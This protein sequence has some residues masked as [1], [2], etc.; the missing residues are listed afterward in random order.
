MHIPILPGQH[1]RVVALSYQCL[2]LI[3]SHCPQLIVTDM[4]L[5]QDLFDAIPSVSVCT[6]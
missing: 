6:G 1:G 3:G 4:A 2:G 5:L